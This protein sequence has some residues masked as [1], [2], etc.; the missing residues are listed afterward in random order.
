[1]TE[2]GYWT[3]GRGMGGRG[4]GEKRRGLCV[5]GVGWGYWDVKVIINDS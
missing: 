4:Q 2:K 5:L 3:G 1:M